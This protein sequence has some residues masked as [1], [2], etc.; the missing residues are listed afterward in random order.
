LCFVELNKQLWIFR[1]SQLANEVNG[2]GRSY[3][4]SGLATVSLK[5]GIEVQGTMK[6]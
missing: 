1:K 6:K 5:S 2:H 3:G 4:G